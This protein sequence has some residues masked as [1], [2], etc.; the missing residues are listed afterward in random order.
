[1]LWIKVSAIN[2][3]VNWGGFMQRLV[4]SNSDHKRELEAAVDS[5]KLVHQPMEMH[6]WLWLWWQLSLLHKDL[7]LD[8][9][10]SFYHM[11]CIKTEYNSV[12]CDW[13]P[14]AVKAL[15]LVLLSPFKQNRQ[16][17]SRAL[18]SIRREN[19]A[20][21]EN[22]PISGQCYGSVLLFNVILQHNKKEKTKGKMRCV[23]VM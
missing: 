1:M 13:G 3:K 22:F 12:F 5:N 2:V 20:S 16:N 17:N 7:E 19:T 9:D 18:M 6:W 23:Y 15:T 11:L 10:R 8:K 21:Y 14:E 4:M